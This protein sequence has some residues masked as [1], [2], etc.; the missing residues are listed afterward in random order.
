LAYPQAD[1]IRMK[2]FCHRWFHRNQPMLRRFALCIVRTPSSKSISQIRM[3]SA[4]L[5]RS[6][7]EYRSLMNTGNTI[8]TFEP[9]RLS[10]VCRLSLVCIILFHS[11]SLYI[12]G[13]YV[14]PCF[15]GSSGAAQGTLQ[16]RRYPAKP[17]NAENFF[18]LV[19]A[20]HVSVRLQQSI[21]SI[22]SSLHFFPD[23]VRNTSRLYNVFSMCAV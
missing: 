5:R 8:G 1:T 20:L 10:E 15:L 6:P 13:V 7:H 4:S 22:V 12:Y 23:G 16:E 11:S 3:P 9:A 21:S 17:F 19:T 18:F 14:V 2:D